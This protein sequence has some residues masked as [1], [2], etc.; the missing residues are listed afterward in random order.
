MKLT[1]LLIVTT[2]ASSLLITGCRDR[3][4]APSPE[5]LAATTSPIVS[6]FQQ[7]GGGDASTATV[8]GLH[9]F[10]SNH[11]E[12]SHSFMFPCLNRQTTADANWIQSP[13]GRIC[14][15]A[16]RVVAEK[17]VAGPEHEMTADTDQR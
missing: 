1:S 6:A 16:S 15:F 7:A 5:S 3:T 11:P 4:S 14:Y 12:L 13:E 9:L 17:R 10:L 8:R 2:Y